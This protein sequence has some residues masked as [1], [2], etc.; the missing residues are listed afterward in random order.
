MQKNNEYFLEA[1][2]AS[3]NNTQ[4]KWSV[5]DI[6]PEEMLQ[7]FQI[8]DIHN[9]TAM[10][11]EA[12]YNCDAAKA[13]PPQFMTMQKRKVIQQIAIQAMKSGEFYG[14][15][16]Q[17]R[18]ADVL[19]CVV[20]GI[21]CR[22]LYPNPDARVSGDEDVFIPE[23]QFDLAHKAL[24]DMG[25]TL[26]NPDKDIYNVYEVPYVKQGSPLY[27]ELHK[28]MFPPESE[29]YGDLNRFFDG[30]HIRRVAPHAGDCGLIEEE[31]DG[32][33][34]LTMNPTDHLLYLILHSFKH[35]LHSGF[36]IRQVCD[37]NLYANAHGAEIDWNYVLEC[38]REVSAEL[39]AASMF[40]IGEKYLT[41]DPV[42][43]CYPDC[44]KSIEVD[45]SF[46]LADLLE[47]GVFGQSDMSRKHSSNITLNA[48]IAD[49][50]GEKASTGKLLAAIK[51]VCLP[52]DKM[53]GRYPYLKKYPFLLPI[54]WI[55]RVWTYR[56]ETAGNKSGNNASESIK[57]GNER[58][59][60]MRKYGI[61]K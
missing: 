48:M 50:R 3:L 44:W 59:E 42:K 57:I 17:L 32:M 49:K 60:L 27:I 20:K 52:V 39:F 37:I 30:I 26:M 21:I 10:I 11:F 46:M 12:V 1:L 5:E 31:V 16:E 41:F 22:K 7:L 6:S 56:K 29:A 28:H 23:N 51:A 15:S 55:Q 53:S 40:V 45:E 47:S 2:K 33:K 19:P 8:A 36:G 14:L 25:M 58:V 35:F 38:L 13:L 43:A 24:L 54:A 9:V 34:F 18:K 61:I 4:V